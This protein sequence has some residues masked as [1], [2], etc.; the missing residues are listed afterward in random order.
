MSFLA[1]FAEANARKVTWH[2]PHGWDSEPDSRTDDVASVSGGR[3]V[4]FLKKKVASWGPA[5]PWDELDLP[6]SD[7]PSVVFFESGKAFGPFSG[8]GCGSPGLFAMGDERDV[9]DWANRALD[10]ARDFDAVVA[11]KDLDERVKALDR[12]LEATNRPVVDH[13]ARELEKCGKAALPV[14]RA[15]LANDRRPNIHFVM[16]C[17]LIDLLGSEATQELTVQLR[18]ELA[19]VRSEELGRASDDTRHYRLITVSVILGHLKE[20]RAKESLPL[21]EEFRDYLTAKDPYRENVTPNVADK[22]QD[23]IDACK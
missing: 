15:T 1:P 19:W 4:L 21:V 2:R 6:Y 14:I 10:S 11:I 12:F 22:C 23:V 5:N 7:A 3:L 18:R 16:A 8:A 17:K 20:E 9:L 13:A